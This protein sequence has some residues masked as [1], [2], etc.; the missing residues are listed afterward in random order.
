[1]TDYRNYKASDL[2]Q[3]DDFVRSVKVPNPEFDAFWAGLVRDGALSG[4]EYNLAKSIVLSVIDE[5]EVMHDEEIKRLYKKIAA[6]TVRPIRI[7][8]NLFY[9]GAA[10]S[11]LL[12]LS[13]G[14]YAFF[15]TEKDKEDA[16]LTA[17]S[18]FTETNSEYVELTL[19]NEERII[20]KE[21]NPTLDY[22]QE[23][24]I[25]I[26]EQIIE[27]QSGATEKA[28][29]EK[30]KTE[31]NR[32]VVPYGKRSSLILEDGTHL[33]VNAGTSVVYPASFDDD[34]REIYVDGEAYLEVVKDN[35]RPFLVKTSDM[36][37]KVL[38]TSFNVNAYKSDNSGAVVLVN[39]SVKVNTNDGSDPYTLQPNDMFTLLDGNVKIRQ[40]DASTFVSWVHGIYIFDNESIKDIVLRLSRYYNVKISVDEQSAGLLCSG[41]LRLKDDIID[42][43]NVIRSA[44][45]VKYETDE[46]GEYKIMFNP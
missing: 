32:L 41:K 12:L 19:A 4:E 3:D 6:E 25:K 43:L 13:I 42:V 30:K 34:R 8:R 22:A 38:G 23:K 44:A 29:K 15:H 16:I 37:I 26:N 45:P 39:G 1:M 11:V 21:D 20:I 17:V 27:K 18:H 9:Y 40:V 28:N 46:N 33:W 10:A 35:K 36:Q 24:N 31:F 2:L 5:R 14:L 7:R